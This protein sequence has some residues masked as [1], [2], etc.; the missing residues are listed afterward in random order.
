MLCCPGAAYYQQPARE[1][2]QHG[3]S[4]RAGGQLVGWRAALRAVQDIAPYP[5]AQALL[6]SLGRQQPQGTSTAQVW[7]PPTPFPNKAQP[8][9]PCVC[10]ACTLQVVALDAQAAYQLCAMS[11]KTLLLWDLRAGPA[12]AA[13]LPLQ[14]PQTVLQAMPG[15]QVLLTA[16]AN[17]QVRDGGACV[18]VFCEAATHLQSTALTPG[19]TTPKAWWRQPHAP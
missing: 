11:G 9:Q 18:R 15:G 5:Q 1:G 14:A 10:V 4:C 6:N 16:A 3:G 7:Q 12:A 8:R 2:W 19:G 17:G 13:A